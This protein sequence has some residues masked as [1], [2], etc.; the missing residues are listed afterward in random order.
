MTDISANRFSGQAVGA[1]PI[2]AN[3]P[4]PSEISVEFTPH[5]LLQ[6]QDLWPDLS[7]K[8]QERFLHDLGRLTELRTE[9]AT[10]EEELQRRKQLLKNQGLIR[11]LQDWR[12]EEA[13]LSP[14][15]QSALTV[16]WGQLEQLLQTER[17]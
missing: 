4:F 12:E 11:L 10:R 15:E 3:S 6:L 5:D 9:I 7:A 1:D 2:R 17:V 16:E 8:E 14:A 13:Q